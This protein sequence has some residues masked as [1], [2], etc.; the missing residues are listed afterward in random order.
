MK[1]LPRLPIPDIKAKFK[2]V[3]DHFVW[4]PSSIER[5][6]EMVMSGMSARMIAPEFGVS[7]NSIIGVCH[8]NGITRKPKPVSI[9][10][11]VRVWLGR[12]G[13]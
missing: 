11:P 1:L 13:R 12:D 6:R 10:G 7:R 4:T 5:V 9:R 3:A 2:P 8:R